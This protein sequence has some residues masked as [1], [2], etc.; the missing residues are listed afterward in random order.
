MSLRELPWVAEA[1]KHIG[2]KEFK[3]KNDNNPIIVG[4]LK[5]MG[6]YTGE[7]RAWW[8]DDDTPWCGLFTG[9]CLGETDR[10]VVKEWYRAKAWADTTHM[11]KLDKPAYGCLAIFTRKGGGHV[12]FVVGKD[13]KGNLMILGGNQGDK[14]SIAPFDPAREPEFFWSSAW[15]KGQYTKENPEPEYYNLPVLTSDGKTGVSEA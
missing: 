15:G 1:R 13:Q 5:A 9:V 4:W 11:T 7:A 6:H 3:G 12:G 10:Y 2:V 14:V 8:A